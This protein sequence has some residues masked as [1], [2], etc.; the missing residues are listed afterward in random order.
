MC[1]IRD[2]F[3]FVASFVREDER[4][5]QVHKPLIVNISWLQP[6]ASVHQGQDSVFVVKFSR[7]AQLPVQ[8]YS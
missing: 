7:P 2:I 5:Q 4:F 8:R 1:V 6:E 3:A